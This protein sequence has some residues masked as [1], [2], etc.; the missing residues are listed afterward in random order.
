MSRQKKKETISGIIERVHFSTPSWSAGLLRANDKGKFPKTIK[1]A[2]SFFAEANDHVSLT[3]HWVV[4]PKYGKQFKVTSVALDIQLDKEGLVSLLSKAGIKSVGKAKAQKIIDK[5]GDSFDDLMSDSNTAKVVA[6]FAKIPIEDFEEF[7]KTWVKNRDTNKAAALLASYE[8]SSFEINTIIA[9][10]GASCLS[11]LQKDPYLI[12]KY[13]TGFGFKKADK[14]ARKL[15]IP[16]ENP[17]RIQAG[18]VHVVW[19]SIKEGNCWI[20]YHDLIESSNLLL[21]LDHFD[22]RRIISV[23]LDNLIKEEELTTTTLGDYVAISTPDLKKKEDDL[24]FVFMNESKKIREHNNKEIESL[25]EPTLNEKQKE[26]VINAFSCS[27]S[28]MSGGAGSGKTYTIS[29][30]KSICDRLGLSLALAAPTGKAARRIEQ[31]LKAKGIKGEASTVHRLLGATGSSFEYHRDYKLSISVLIIDEVSMMDVDLGWHLFNA[32]DFNRTK[33][34]L[35]GDHNQLPPVGAG[36]ILRDLINSKAIPT[37]I[38]DETMRQAGVLKENCMA[39]LNGNVIETTRESKDNYDGW[40]ML[41]KSTEIKNVSDFLIEMFDWRLE[42][43]GFNILD[44]VQL[45]TPTHKGDLGTKALNEKLQRLIQMKIYG[46]EVPPIKPGRRPPFLLN[47]KVI[48][49]KNNYKLDVMNGQIGFVVD[50]V[51]GNL[52]VEF[53]GKKDYVEIR[54]G[55]EAMRNLQLAYALSIHKVQGSEFPCTVVII[56][57]SHSFMH[58]RN[59]LYTAVTRAQKSVFILG[60]K[61]GVKNCAKKQQSDMRRTFLS[62]Y[63]LN[64]NNSSGNVS[65]Y[66]SSCKNGCKKDDI[67]NHFREDTKMVTSDKINAK[68]IIDLST[69]DDVYDSVEVPAEKKVANKRSRRDMIFKPK[70]VKDYDDDYMEIV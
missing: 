27:L 43:A 42:K 63:L 29:A 19:D 22:S 18:I 12:A 39:V 34:I 15:G 17:Q 69:F 52:V 33:V 67:D 65:D 1:I 53:E 3:G 25:C 40:F 21:T 45:I 66:K 31:S 10:F 68:N 11:I 58:H 62:Y 14:I 60:D 46:V 49:M 30:I 20:E 16:K 70:G 8:L 55:T 51:K 2:G 38:L 13:I 28:L 32:I 61:W 44:D 5:Y 24:A 36:N 50:I 4:D 26:A 35:V 6:E 56:H 59:L 48:N 47:D 41:N 54:K 37:T 7:R 9:R 57:K 23:Q 64:E